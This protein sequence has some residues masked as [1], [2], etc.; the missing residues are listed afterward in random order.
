MEQAKGPDGASLHAFASRGERATQ[1]RGC[2]EKQSPRL[3]GHQQCCL[4]LALLAQCRDL[5]ISFADGENGYREAGTSQGEAA[6]A[7]GSLSVQ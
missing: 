3:L 5:L 4:S 7:L 1:A 6:R 2:A